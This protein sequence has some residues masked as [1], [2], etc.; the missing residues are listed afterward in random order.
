MLTGEIGSQIDKIWDSFWSGIANPLE[1]MEQITYMLFLRRLGDLH[2]LE[3]N[4]ATL[5]KIKNESHGLGLLVRSLV[6][7]DH[8]AAKD[9]ALLYESPFID[10]N[11]LGPDGVFNSEQVGELI[12]LLDKVRGNAV[13][14]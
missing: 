13:A 5:E 8:E 6:G 9:A 2:R 4:K 7:L 12:S 1:A 11:P 10:I 14:A 3:E